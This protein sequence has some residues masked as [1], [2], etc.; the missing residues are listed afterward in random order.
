LFGAV[1]G[2]LVGHHVAGKD[3]EARIGGFEIMPYTDMDRASD[4]P[5]TGL[6]LIKRF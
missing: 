1:W 5:V 4:E 2:Y 3:K 6:S